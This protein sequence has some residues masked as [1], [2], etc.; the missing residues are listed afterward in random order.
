MEC[1]CKGNEVLRVKRIFF[2]VLA[3]LISLSLFLSNIMILN[4]LDTH[5]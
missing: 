3:I 1:H 2:H 5:T 4:S